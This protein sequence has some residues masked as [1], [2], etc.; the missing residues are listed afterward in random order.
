[1]YRLFHVLCWLQTFGIGDHDAGMLKAISDTANG[2]YYFLQDQGACSFF[3]WIATSYLADKIPESVG[4]CLGGLL[5]VVG[6]N[7]TMTIEGALI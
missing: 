4:D 7:V 1:M 3:E 5:S 2:I 6:T